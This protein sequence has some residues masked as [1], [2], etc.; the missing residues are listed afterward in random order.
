MSALF[1]FHFFIVL[2]QVKD[3]CTFDF[4]SLLY[5]LP[6]RASDK[7]PSLDVSELNIVLAIL[8]KWD[9]ARGMRKEATRDVLTELVQVH[10]PSSTG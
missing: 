3:N 6:N 7:M 1:I 9:L 5:D 2:L 10:S 8:G 4:L